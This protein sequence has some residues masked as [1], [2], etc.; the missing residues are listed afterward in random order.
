M[1][2]CEDAFGSPA[3]ISAAVQG[4]AGTKSQIRL[5]V[6]KVILKG[7]REKNVCGIRGETDWLK[8]LNPC[9]TEQHSL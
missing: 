4:E 9:T 8:S 7:Q 2:E 1:T 5:F 6:N 3:A